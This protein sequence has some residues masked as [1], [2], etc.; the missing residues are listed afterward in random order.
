[1]NSFKKYNPFAEKKTPKELAKEAQRETKREVR[2]SQRGMDRELRELDRQEKQLTKELKQRAKIT[3]SGKD[4]ALAALAKQ[5]VQT[6]KQREKIMTAKAHIGAVAMNA[7]SMATQVAAAAAIGNVSNAMKVTNEAMNVKE[8]TKILQEFQRENEKLEVKQ[9]LMDDALMDAFDN[10]DIEDEAEQVTN[11]VLA[12][13]GVEMDSKMIGLNAPIMQ[14][15][16]ENLSTEEQEALDA[17]LPDLK[18]RLDAL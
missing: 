12:E 17:M 15:V 8:T 6:R 4:P 10:E 5:L 11:Q 2:S 14:P 9:E 16:G 3:N 1:M 18:S 13:L 7:S